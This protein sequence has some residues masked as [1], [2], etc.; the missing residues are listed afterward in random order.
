MTPRPQSRKSGRQ[1][2]RR[3]GWERIKRIKTDRQTDRQTDINNRKA[4]GKG[5]N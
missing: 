4:N 5:E 1:T 2:D 3:M